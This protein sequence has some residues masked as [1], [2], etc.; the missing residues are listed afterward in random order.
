MPA[1][2]FYF[3]LHQCARLRRYSIFD[4]APN[5]F[6]DAATETQ[7]RHAATECYVPA[8]RILL[9]LARDLPGQF[10]AALSIS[11]LA[12]ELLER[13]APEV[14]QHLHALAATG[15][16]EFVGQPY[17]HS[18]SVLYSR[19]EFLSQVQLHKQML[20]RLFN[21]VP[22]SFANTELLYNNDV[23]RCVRDMGFEAILA[24]GVESVLASRSAAFVYAAPGTARQMRLLLRNRALSDAIGRRLADPTA[25]DFPLTV[26]KV[27]RSISKIGGQL[28]NLFFDLESFGLWQPKETALDLLEKLPAKL[29]AANCRLLT[30]SQACDQFQSAGEL[31]TPQMTSWCGANRD[32]ACWLGNAMQ[33]SAVQELYRLEPVLSRRAAAGDQ[34]VLAEFRKLTAAD[35]A[36]AMATRLEPPDQRRAPGGA[37]PSPYDAYIGFMNILENLRGQA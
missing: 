32:L 18:L 33:K 34:D 36:R 13:H 25:P 31:S 4:T 7:V 28:C 6:D 19:G 23:G 29:L 11:G 24:E 21:I 17:H 10:K 15:C 27:V 22:R 20:K 16:C 37:V 2:C 26:D 12:V 9:Q 30:P 1:V 14:L 35:Y 5:Y 3:S 8:L